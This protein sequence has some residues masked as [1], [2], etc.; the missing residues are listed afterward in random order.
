MTPELDLDGW[1]NTPATVG[2]RRNF[3]LLVITLLDSAKNGIVIVK[4]SPRT[5][6]VQKSDV[7]SNL[8]IKFRSSSK[9]Q[10]GET[11]LH[12]IFRMTPYLTSTIP[13][14]FFSFF[15]CFFTPSPLFAPPLSL[16]L[17]LS[18]APFRHLG[19]F[20]AKCFYHL[21]PAGVFSG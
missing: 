3:A 6:L 4:R 5:W 9:I 8:E 20:S 19:M 1:L 12:D 21:F 13:Y 7:I 15:L 10:A 18:R 14:R 2:L 17:H 11:I 16:F